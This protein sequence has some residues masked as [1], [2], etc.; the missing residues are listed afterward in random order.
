MK[1]FLLPV[2]DLTPYINDVTNFN[3]VNTTNIVN[4]VNVNISNVLPNGDNPECV[5]ES[6]DTF[7]QFHENCGCVC[8]VPNGGISFLC[9]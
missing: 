6:N 7:G 2:R 1:H 4:D 8:N 9:D 3:D 5:N